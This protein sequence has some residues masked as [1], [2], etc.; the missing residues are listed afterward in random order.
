MCFVLECS[1]GLWDR[2]MAL[3]VLHHRTSFTTNSMTIDWIH[4]ILVASYAKLLYSTIALNLATIRYFC[5]NHTTRFSPWNMCTPEVNLQMSKHI[6]QSA[7]TNPLMAN[8]IEVS[9]SMSKSIILAK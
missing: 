2:A 9:N 7:S 3:G 1:R 4:V 6:A 8:D 5:A